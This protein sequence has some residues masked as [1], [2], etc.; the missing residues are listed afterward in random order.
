MIQ[1]V[2]NHNGELL[3]YLVCPVCEDKEQARHLVLTIPYLAEPEEETIAGI[4]NMAAF[5][6]PVDKGLYKLSIS[7][8]ES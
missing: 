7:R 8:A 3:V 4:Y 6:C 1:I 2:L 5:Q